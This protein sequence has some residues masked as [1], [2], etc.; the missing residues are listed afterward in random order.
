VSARICTFLALLAAVVVAPSAASAHHPP[1]ARAPSLLAAGLAG[2]MGSTV[3]PGHKLYVAEPLEGRIARVD[4]ETGAVTTFADGLPKESPAVGIGGVMDVDF[5]GHTAYALVTLVGPD[6]GG[7]NIDG[8]YR[9]DG[10]HSF[11][12]VADIGRWAIAHPPSTDFFVPSGLQYAMQRYRDGWLVTDGH[13]NRVLRAGDD[14]SVSEFRTFGDIVPTGLALR[15][16]RV[17]MAEAGPIPHLPANGKIVSFGAS[18]PVTEVAAGGPLMVDVEFGPGHSLYGLAQGHWSDTDPGTPAD[19]DTGQL[20]LANCDGTFTLVADKLDRPTSLELIGDDA[21]I[22][23]LDGEV[24]K[25]ADVPRR[26]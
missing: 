8:I 25:V 6:V 2:G 16:S 18:S 10:P 26:D 5:V 17:Y 23:T 1:G 24:W 14:G 22:V 3:G 11:T 13:H 20:L 12:V 9:V 15:G 21:Y 19:P 7:S 4:P